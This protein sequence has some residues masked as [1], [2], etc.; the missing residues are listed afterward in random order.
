MRTP[1][2]QT[3][4]DLITAVRFYTESDLQLKL[5]ETRRR[6]GEYYLAL[7]RWLETSERLIGDIKS[8]ISFIA[9]ASL[10]T[11]ETLK[12][13]LKGRDAALAA[14]FTQLIGHF[15]TR[16]DFD[17]SMLDGLVKMIAAYIDAIQTTIVTTNPDLLRETITHYASNK[18]VERFQ[19]ILNASKET[20]LA[21]PG[22]RP[23]TGMTPERQALAQTAM[24]YQKQRGGAWWEIGKAV[25]DDLCMAGQS[26]ER[27][28]M[29][30]LLRNYFALDLS[31]VTDKQG[32]G[33]YLSDL[34][35]DLK[36]FRK[37]GFSRTY[38][39]D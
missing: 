8:D 7:N 23:A 10:T 14:R 22:G 32:L 36:K 3:Q 2:R 26:L 27:D 15:R 19:E 13:A 21:H 28:A 11:G 37:K 29:I 25:M 20:K 17:I 33:K 6:D 39:L 30:D 4:T 31:Y 9:G 12:A 35:A 18:A 16:N 38:F 5:A 24:A 1:T 34:V